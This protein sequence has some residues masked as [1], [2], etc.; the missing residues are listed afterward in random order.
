MRP[1]ALAYRSAY[2]R[3]GAVRFAHASSHYDTTIAFY[4]DLVRLPVVDEFT[5]SFG[6]DGTIFG[7]PDPAVQLEIVRANADNDAPGSFDQLVLYFDGAAAATTATAPLVAVGAERVLDPHPYWAA[8]GA[9]VY[10][11]PDGR[12]VVFVP[13]V[14]GG[15]A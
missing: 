11:D 2:M 4:R 15:E 14:Y 9:I 5:N 8:N 13:W 12:H 10:R 1:H 3:P 7:L 6:E